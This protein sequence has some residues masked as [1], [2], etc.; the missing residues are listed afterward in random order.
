MKVTSNFDP[1]SFEDMNYLGNVNVE[2]VKTFYSVGY[3]SHR[4]N[5]TRKLIKDYFDM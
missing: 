4:K 5:K 1:Q 3:Q 2:I